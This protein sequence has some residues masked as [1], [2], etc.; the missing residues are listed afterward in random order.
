MS[1]SAC[2]VTA[3]RNTS[4]E[5]KG[6]GTNSFASPPLLGTPSR[7]CARRGEQRATP[8]ARICPSRDLLISSLS[9][10]SRPDATSSQ[11]MT[12][13][14]VAEYFQ[15]HRG[16]LYRLVRKGKI[17]YFKMGSDYRFDKDAIDKWTVERQ[18]KT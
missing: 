15:I 12:L 8:F 2:S 7:L 11:I 5:L 3:K 13:S 9:M 18:I 16:T 1:M 6:R 10:N 17:P 4:L 14:E